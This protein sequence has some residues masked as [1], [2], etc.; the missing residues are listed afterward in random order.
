MIPHKM[1]IA[2]AKKMHLVEYLASLE[3]QK[4]MLVKEK[5][6]NQ[7]KPIDKKN[8]IKIR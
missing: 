4:K 5:N 7:Q 1:T 3:L 6:I 8:K 2:E